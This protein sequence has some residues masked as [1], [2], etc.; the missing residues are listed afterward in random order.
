MKHIECHGGGLEVIK[1]LVFTLFIV[2]TPAMGFAQD[3]QGWKNIKWGMTKTQVAQMHKF[4]WCSEPEEIPG[5]L[6]CQLKDQIQIRSLPFYVN[7]IFDKLTDNGQVISVQLTCSESSDSHFRDIYEILT[8][9]YG[10]TYSRKKVVK[11]LMIYLWCGQSGHIEYSTMSVLSDKIAIVIYK[12]GQ[13]D[14]SD[15]DNM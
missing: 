3:I 12:K 15:E 14:R 1:A 5:V 4:N 2:L 8:R 11:G 13:G 6:N 9:K 7:V 10:S